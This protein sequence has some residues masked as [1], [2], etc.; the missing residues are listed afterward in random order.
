MPWDCNLNQND[1]LFITIEDKLVGEIYDQKD[2]EY[3]VRAANNFQ[4]AIELL[5]M[6]LKRDTVVL[7]KDLIKTKNIGY[8]KAFDKGRSRINK[9]LNK[10]NEIR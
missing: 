9:F 3:L 4:E 5:K 7:D 2:R 1:D 6:I 8:V 10:L